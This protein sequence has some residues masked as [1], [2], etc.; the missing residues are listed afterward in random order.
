MRPA[1]AGLAALVVVVGCGPGRIVRRG[2]VNEDALSVVVRELPDIR[3]LP[4][5]EPVPAFAMMP[6]EIRA[7]LASELE[8]NYPPGDLATL[9]AVYQRLGLLP[10]D[11]DL[12]AAVQ[13]IYEEEG[14]GFY[15]P[16]GKRLVLAT[17]ALGSAGFWMGLAATLTGRD[18]VGEFLV[19]HELTHALQ[20]QLFGLPV[21][22]DPIVNAHGDRFLAHHALYEGDATLA[23]FAYV[24]RRQLDRDQIAAI[25]DQLHAVPDQLAASHPD[26]PT[27]L[28]AS[29][30]VQYDAGTTFVGRALAAGGWPAVDQIYRDPP[31]SI[32]QVLHPE[33]YFDRRDRPVAITLA[34]TDELEA[35]GWTRVV[36][37][38]LGELGVRVVAERALPE[39]DAVRVADGWDGD[40]L[41]ALRRGGELLLVW[42]TA[43]D[44]V[45]DAGEFVAAL[46]ALFPGAR[47]THRDQ[48]ALVVLGPGR[49][50]TVDLALLEARL[51]K[52]TRTTPA[53]TS[54][55]SS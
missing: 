21:A 42:M 33:R 30:A 19:A 55:R 24:A 16:R 37:D 28:R 4:F 44:S 6:E 29:L 35:D 50:S 12:R 20:D 54:P 11:T 36:E 53:D 17:R 34:G 14:A 2:Q 18:L 22:A 43:W 7:L 46:P 26:L 45:E 27:L 49:A 9:S 40:R 15:D 47:I 10:P 38:T 39:A 25:T 3:G 5:T 8:H 23:G 31:E 51:W 48:R 41:R 13:R 1:L 32:E 52:R